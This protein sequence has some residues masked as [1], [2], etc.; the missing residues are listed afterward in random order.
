MLGGLISGIMKGVGEGYA[1]VAKGELENQQKLDYQQKYLDMLEEKE[2]RISEHQSDVNIKGKIREIKEVD[3]LK[4]ESEANRTRVVGEA[5]TGVLA[6]REDALRP[7]KIQTAKDTA[8]AQGEAERANLGAY[9]GDSS[10]RAGVRA[11]ASDQE[12]SAAKAT[13]AAA[14]FELAQKRGVADLRAKL[15]STT[16]PDTRKALQQQISDLS[17]GSTKSYSD[18]VTAGDAFRKLAANLRTQLK[19]DPTLSDTEQ[20][21]IKQRITLYET[22]AADVLGTTV[23][24]RLGGGDN[25]GAPKASANIVIPPAAVEK[26]KA[27]P[28][29]RSDFDAKYGS[30]Q[31]AKILGNTK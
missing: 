20:A 19:D 30:G 6:G 16:D 21:E 5:E 29:L 26:L 14:S 22:Q 9:A 17:G 23:E 4:T 7:G 28:N 12:G 13:A 8:L 10:A 11:K 18:M 27:N 25:K 31:A 15:A 2:K 3:P 1:T 24:R